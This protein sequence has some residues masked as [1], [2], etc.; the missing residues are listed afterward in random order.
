M[1]LF[2]DNE[3][4]DLELALK[5][6]YKHLTKYSSFFKYSIVNVQAFLYFCQILI[7]F[8]ALGR[9]LFY[10]FSHLFVGFIEKK[11]FGYPLR[12]FIFVFLQLN[13]FLKILE[14]FLH[15]GLFLTKWFLIKLNVADASSKKE[16]SSFLDKEPSWELPSC[17]FVCSAFDFDDSF[18]IQVFPGA[19]IG[20]FEAFF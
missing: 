3:I 4:I 8:N 20:Y 17:F 2:V 16:L 15:I 7:I 1:F 12:N 19:L 13:E 14:G 18:D 6:I 10:W 5:S 9:N 11:N